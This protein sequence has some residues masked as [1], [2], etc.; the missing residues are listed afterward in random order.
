M[1]YINRLDTIPERDKQIDRQTD[2]RTDRIAVWTSRVN[3][4]V[5]TR[6]KNKTLDCTQRAQTS[7]KASNLNQ[8]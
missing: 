5:L 7:A 4:A 8:K 6:D 1:M 2:G 3:S